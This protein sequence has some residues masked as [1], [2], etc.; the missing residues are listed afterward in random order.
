MKLELV[1]SRETG[2][3][4][5]I[6]VGHSGLGCLPGAIPSREKLGSVS[7]IE[8]DCHLWSEQLLET[9]LAEATGLTGRAMFWEADLRRRAYDPETLSMLSTVLAQGRR[10]S[11]ASRPCW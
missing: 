1:R 7:K 9:R 10:A 5:P 3:I 4:A 8:P 11:S 6:S 2:S